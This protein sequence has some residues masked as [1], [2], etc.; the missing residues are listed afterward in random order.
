MRWRARSGRTPTARAL[1]A[2]GLLVVVATAAVAC[3]A[4][5][6]DGGTARPGQ[7]PRTGG[8]DAPA[9]P[10][11]D[12]TSLWPA[13]GLLLGTPVY[14]GDFADPFVL[15]VG[16][17][18][19][20]YATNTKDANLPVIVV[21]GSPRGTYYGDAFP[22]LPS[23][24]EP[25]HVW[26]P[27]VLDLGHRFVLYYSTRVGGTTMQCIS[28][29][30]ADSPTG[31]FVDDSTGPMVCQRDLGGSIDPSVVTDTDGGN[32]L[33]YKNDG[34]CCG[35]PTSIWSVRLRADGLATTGEE[36]KLLTA[37]AL[38]EGGLIEAPSMVIDGR[39]H[40]L[41]YSGNAWDSDRYG[42]GYA[43]CRSMTGPCRKV[44]TDGPWMS[45]TAFAKGPGGQEFFSALGQVW[46][47]YH[48]WARGDAGDPGA[49]RRLYLD[50]VEFHDGV[51]T[52][53]GGRNAALLLLLGAGAAVAGSP[54]VV[55]LLGAGG[56]GGGGRGRPRERPPGGG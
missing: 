12:P 45:S 36:T 35:I 56:S 4:G 23:W 6:S 31:P 26:A 19:Y 51:P 13:S 39:H 46:M 8:P 3:G 44:T 52:R 2:V 17:T 16:D 50:V 38:W 10:G 34:N 30:V 5:G 54:L 48:G 1:G 33:L 20:A 18:L 29:A 41:F 42:I 11:G 21:R 49:E 25:G 55:W 43:E 14:R 15:R 47:V 7:R 28:R 9:R 37:G 40:V 32:W 27:A 24:S 22:V 53:V